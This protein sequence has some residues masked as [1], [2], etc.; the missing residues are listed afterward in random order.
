MNIF[1]LIPIAFAIITIIQLKRKI[2][3]KRKSGDWGIGGFLFSMLIKELIDGTSDIQVVFLILF[4]FVFV[5]L[6]CT[7]I[8]AMY[9]IGATFL[10]G[11]EYYIK[12]KD[13]FC[14][15]CYYQ[16]Q[17]YED[18]TYCPE[19]GTKLKNQCNSCGK[20]LSDK[21]INICPYCVKEIE[22]KVG[23]IQND[24]N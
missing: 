21:D 24:S 10:T 22:F 19:C 13:E 2:Q 3:F 14:P 6:I 18:Y 15:N 11:H 20:T 7:L 1:I 23:D 4:V 5:S 9:W 12:Q 8:V 16:Y 17:A